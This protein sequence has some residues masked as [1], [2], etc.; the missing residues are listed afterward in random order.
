M[1]AAGKVAP[2]LVLPVTV[3]QMDDTVA[4]KTMDEITAMLIDPESDEAV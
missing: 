3:Q 4:D 2:E 1:A